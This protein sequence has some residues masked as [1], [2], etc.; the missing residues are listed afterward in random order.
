MAFDWKTYNREYQRKRRAAQHRQELIKQGKCPIS[1][2][3]LTSRYH[4][5]DC[6]CGIRPIAVEITIETYH[7]HKKT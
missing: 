6:P 7:I 4:D 2:I 3:L 5:L 1:E